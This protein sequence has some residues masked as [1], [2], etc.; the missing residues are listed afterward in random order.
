MIVP[1]YDFKINVTSKKKEHYTGV[2]S[3]ALYWC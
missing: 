2:N 1:V 3:E